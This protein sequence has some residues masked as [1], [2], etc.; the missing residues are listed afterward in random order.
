MFAYTSFKYHCFVYRCQWAYLNLIT[1]II[2]IKTG[3]FLHYLCKKNYWI[4]INGSN[5]HK[6]NVVFSFHCSPCYH[7]CHVIKLS[8]VEISDFPRKLKSCGVILILQHVVFFSVFLMTCIYRI[9]QSVLY[10]LNVTHISS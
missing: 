6:T 8:R 9:D 3:N 1:T 5:C 10:I 4:T 7:L 2:A